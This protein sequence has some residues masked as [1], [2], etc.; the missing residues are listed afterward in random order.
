MKQLPLSL[1]LRQVRR[2]QWSLALLT[3]VMC[4]S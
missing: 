1:L 3:A 4:G 2:L